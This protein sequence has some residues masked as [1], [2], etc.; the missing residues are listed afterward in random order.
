VTT[1]SLSPSS[2]PAR[3]GSLHGKVAVVSGASSGNG[4]AIARRLAADGAGVIC[5][6]LRPTPVPDG[7]DGDEPTHLVIAAAG[8]AAEFVE[9][10]VTSDG[11][12]AR[13]IAVARD[14]YGRIDIVVA[15]AGVGQ[16][17]GPLHREAPDN[18]RRV[19][20][21]NL[22]GAWTTVRHGLDAL[23]EQ[24]DGGRIITMSS[25]A[26]LVGI[27]G[28]G[29]SSYSVT[30]AAIVQLTR[31]AALD[32]APYGVTANAVCPGYVRTA[33]NKAV[34]SDPERLAE[35]SARHPLGRMG[36]TTDVAAAVA[37]L[38]S[39]D[40]AWITGVA[41]PVDGGFTCV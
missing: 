16:G 25:I 14:R 18:W 30:K 41:L 29:P 32:G 40:A 33:I 13:A 4:R 34:W 7:L 21:V 15:N 23:I 27:P 28:G 24:G 17:T 20:D 26:G 39:A 22:T 31:Q 1:P 9:W 38:A 8:G 5:G 12:T 19:L 36:E 37:F 2:D 10:D 11:D 3:G 6:D 35:V